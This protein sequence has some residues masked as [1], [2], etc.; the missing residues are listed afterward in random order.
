MN[1]FN[2][3]AMLQARSEYAKFKITGEQNFKAFG[4]ETEMG[5]FK[6]KMNTFFEEIG[7]VGYHPKRRELTAHIR[8]KRPTGYSGELCEKGSFEYVRFYLDYGSGWED[9]GFVGVN[10]HDIPTEEDC[11][12]QA[13]KP[14]DYVARLRIKPKSKKCSTPVLPRVRA[15][16]TWSSIP[17]PNDPNL[18]TPNI[19]VWGDVKDDTIQIK[20][21]E[22]SLPTLDLDLING[23][24]AISN[25][26]HFDLSS[27]KFGLV[28]KDDFQDLLEIYQDK[29]VP[30]E[31]VG[32][33]LIKEAESTL[34]PMIKLNIQELFSANEL[35]LSEAYEAFLSLKCNT[36]YEEL[37]CVGADYNREALVGTLRIKRPF[38][39]NGNLCKNGSKEYVSFW[40]QDP[41]TCKWDNVG[42]T[43]ISAHDIATIPKGGLSYS[44]I[45]PYNFENYKENCKRP[46][47]LKVRAVLSWNSK[48]SGMN[49]S[50]YGN[51]IESYVQIRPKVRYGKEPKLIA[52]GNVSVSNIN[53]STGLTIP[54]SKFRENQNPLYDDSPF[55]GKI[56]IEG[57]SWQN[58]SLG[59]KVRIYNHTTGASYYLNSDFVVEDVNGNPITISAVNDVYSYKTFNQNPDNI[60]MNFKPGGNDKITIF[61]E[62]LNGTFDFQTIQLDN[63]F[64]TVS[65]TIDDNGNCT[66]YVKGGNIIGEFSVDDNYL[67]RYAVTTNL[68]TYQK[69]GPGTL[70]QSGTV[71]GDG[72]FI[73]STLTTINCGSINL[74]AIQKT[75]WDSATTGTYR[76]INK[77]VCL[78]D[79]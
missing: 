57:V 51:V 45:L 22:S 78:K 42:T 74:K 65:L 8:I 17:A 79:A 41:E 11:S 23:P 77:I 43:Y 25:V 50:G 44:A 32:Y 7:C 10:V 18:T 48:P 39:Y 75:I 2:E 26:P 64:P 66:H 63:T 38:G 6:E 46:Q 15:V 35:N 13:N 4:F 30:V 56:V 1:E 49:C 14:L 40:I 33:K 20:P 52:I 29:K 28:E 19:Y 24:L 21:S 59:Y 47:V 58:H 69:T 71:T 54:G 73:I 53:D 12:S 60:L 67:E 61:I 3:K 27:N 34:D 68:G 55:G 31:R 16:L 36:N 72:N 37:F 5:I 70:N 76:Q 62:H 9:Q